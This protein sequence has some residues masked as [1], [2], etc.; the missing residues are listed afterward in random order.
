M[1]LLLL[2]RKPPALF[3]VHAVPFLTDSLLQFAHV[4]DASLIKAVFLD[5]LTIV[6]HVELLRRIL[7]REEHDRFLAARVILQEMSDVVN[8]VP[9][10]APAVCVSVVLLN[11]SFAH[12]HGSKPASSLA[13]KR[14]WS[15]M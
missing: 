7:A 14:T 4:F 8:I 10:D 11:L 13:L 5:H 9:H 1:N 12:R 15:P 2:E 3:G 6:E